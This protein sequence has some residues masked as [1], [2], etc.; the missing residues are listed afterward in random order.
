MITAIDGTTV[1]SVGDVEK[2]VRA[3]GLSGRPLVLQLARGSDQVQVTLRPARDKDGQYRLGLYI[4]DTAA[5]VGTL[6]FYDPKTRRFAP[7]ATSS[8]TSTRASPF[9][10][11][12][13]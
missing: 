4:R 12:M 6:T 1:Q 7:W 5:G 10:S 8:P 2:Q 9:A 13:A 11:A 3:A